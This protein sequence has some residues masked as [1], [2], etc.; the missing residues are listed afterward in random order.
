MGHCGENSK[1][2]NSIQ[3]TS[4][5]ALAKFL[6]KY[7]FFKSYKERLLVHIA[8]T[9]TD[10]NSWRLDEK[11]GTLPLCCSVFFVTLSRSTRWV[12]STLLSFC[13]VHIISSIAVL[14]MNLS[15]NE[16]ISFSRNAENQTRGCWVQSKN[17]I[18][19]AMH[20]FVYVRTHKIRNCRTRWQCKH[21]SAEVS[22]KINWA[23]LGFKPTHFRLVYSCQGFTLVTW[24]CISTINYF[25]I[26]E[27]NTL[28]ELFNSLQ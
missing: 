12:R 13:T 18:H 15:N 20:N 16:R 10:S 1:K 8:D 2:Y 25:P 3:G 28:G 11:L 27:A 26:L 21:S 7:A 4:S 6:P 24:I 14:S 9:Q 17:A 5:Q 22:G 19:C 23:A